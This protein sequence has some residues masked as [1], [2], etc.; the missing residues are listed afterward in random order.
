MEKYK[1]I[2]I[3]DELFAIQKLENYI[4]L[5]PNLSLLKYY[6]DPLEA[7]TELLKIEPVDLILMDINMPHI[8]GIELSKE[9]RQK[10]KK[11]VITTAHTQ[12][13]YD[14]FEV[15]ADAYLL[16]PFSLSKF[17]STIMRLFPNHYDVHTA[18]PSED[19]FFVKN[20]DEGLKI[21]KVRFTEIVSVESK[22]NY[23]MIHTTK[24][25]ILTY[26]SLTEISK[27]LMQFNYFVQF[28]RSFIIS[29]N[30]IEHIEGNMIKMSTGLVI[31]VGDYYRKDFSA[32]LTE[33]LIKTGRKK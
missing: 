3:D 28:Q 19:F 33:R 16:K 7:L 17:A 6:T 30:F 32:F 18:D 29:K 15:N 31:S 5:I 12:Y 23:I 11:L 14:A 8:S 22:L 9:V 2:I 24:K 13:G 1:C 27:I 25:K 21:V 10:T 26:M 4:S 20:K